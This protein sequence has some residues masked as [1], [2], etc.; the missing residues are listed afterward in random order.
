VLLA[1]TEG[2]IWG[3]SDWR[4]LGSLGIGLIGIGLFVWW[5]RR[6]EAPMINLKLFDNLAFSLSLLAAF[7]SFLA[8]AFNF[9][10]LPFYLQNVLNYDPQRT[11][12][13]L[14]AS[15]IILSLASP[16]SG[17]LSDRFGSRWI[18]AGGLAAIALG[19]LSMASLTTTSSE[20]EVI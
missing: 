1:L 17:R 9:L 12:L 15:P 2:Q 18:A 11:G 5:E 6:I 13:T 19:L 20:L 7:A 10:L 4:T 16:V 3:F 8:G 14:I